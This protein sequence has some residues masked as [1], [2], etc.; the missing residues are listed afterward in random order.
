MGGACQGQKQ[1]SLRCPPLHR[2]TL[3]HTLSQHLS[4]PYHV[5][6]H[7]CQSGN[8]KRKGGIEQWKKREG[9]TQQTINCVAGWRGRKTERERETAEQ[10]KGERENNKVSLVGI[11]LPHTAGVSVKA[12]WWLMPRFA[13]SGHRQELAHQAATHGGFNSCRWRAGRHVGR[14]G[15]NGGRQEV[16]CLLC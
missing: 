3:S 12:S 2:H 16:T 9:G 6:L 14:R 4:P 15:G 10:R 5:P 8:R 7:I 13:Y 1:R 11:N